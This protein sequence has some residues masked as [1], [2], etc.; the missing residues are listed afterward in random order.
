MCFAWCPDY[1]KSYKIKFREKLGGNLK[2]IIYIYKLELK[3][4]IYD[5]NCIKTFYKIY[6]KDNFHMGM[7]M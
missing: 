6:N 4:L 7:P 1:E 3:Q 5:H 2:N